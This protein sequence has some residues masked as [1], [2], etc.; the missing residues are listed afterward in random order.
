MALLSTVL[1]LATLGQ[2]IAPPTPTLTPSVEVLA[3]IDQAVERA[4]DRRSLPA[5]Q[6]PLASPQGPWAGLQ[7]PLASPQGP[8]GVNTGP[9]ARVRVYLPLGPFRTTGQTLAHWLRDASR[10]RVVERELATD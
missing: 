9:K 3:A 10:P 8:I 1:V 2:E 6:T 7:G 5:P 4:L